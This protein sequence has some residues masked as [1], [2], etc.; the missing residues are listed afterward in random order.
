[1]VSDITSSSARIWTRS[2]LSNSVS[3]CL[4]DGEG[5]S[6]RHCSIYTPVERDHTGYVQIT[7]LPPDTRYT[8]SV[9][10]ELSDDW[11]FKT[12]PASDQVCRIAFGSCANEKAG[13]SEVWN[14]IDEDNATAVVL[15]G[16]TPYIDTTDLSVQRK[17]YREFAS[18]PAFSSLVS[19][20][21]L[22]ATWDDHD[23]GRNDTDGNLKGKENS[24]KAFGEY[25]PNPSI[26]ERGEGIYTSFTQGPVEVFLLDTRWFAGTEFEDEKPTLLGAQ[27]WEWLSRSLK[28]ST[29]PY[30]ILACGMIFNNAVR[31][32]KRDYWGAYPHEYDRLL[33]L[34]NETNT[35]G[36]I[37]V[38][39]DIHW[40]RVIQHD[41]ED[42][43]GY[44]LHE[45]I[46]S[47]I[48]EKLIPLANAPH[49]GIVYT[50]GLLNSFLLV[51]TLNEGEE[52]GLALKMRTAN[53]ETAYQH[54]FLAP[55][56]P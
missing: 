13:S 56:S 39:G 51:E 1:M 9:G 40:S 33:H 23:F 24:R 38:S 43:I 34:I 47:P 14:R 10:G 22:Y 53:G 55:P 5:N 3:I 18:V 36:I 37:L 17:R 45:F 49:P 16:D 30:K 26:G 29:S 42:K 4:I 11:W 48:H 2:E 44:D 46:T 54:N 52:V 6:F 35:T 20:V 27:Q 7:N 15:L 25:R 8:Y 31:P 32:L 41:T 28:A 12:R 21:P 50:G 19:H